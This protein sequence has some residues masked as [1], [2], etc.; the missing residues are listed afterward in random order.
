MKARL[1][2]AHNAGTQ[3]G[4][5]EFEQNTMSNVAK[6]LHWKALIHTALVDGASLKRL[7]T[8]NSH[9]SSRAAARLTHQRYSY[10]TRT[11][12]QVFRCV[13]R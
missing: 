11:L 6:S 1:V 9:Q 3:P 10:Y 8:S 7:D 13:R 4:G 5:S 2:W 12:S